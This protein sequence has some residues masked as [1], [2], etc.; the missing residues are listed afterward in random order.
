M[1]SE[2]LDPNA[3]THIPNEDAAVSVW[4][5]GFSC[6]NFLIFQHIPIKYRLP[7]ALSAGTD[8]TMAHWK[9]SI[10]LSNLDP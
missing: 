7:M 4:Q 10:S 9:T 8:P 3:V 5:S 6:Q 1:N 2:E